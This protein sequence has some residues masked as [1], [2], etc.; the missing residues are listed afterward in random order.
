VVEEMTAALEAEVAA[1]SS[2]ATEQQQ[3][4][5]GAPLATSGLTALPLLQL[6]QGGEPGMSELRSALGEPL[7]QRVAGVVDHAATTGLLWGALQ[8]LLGPDLPS[9]SVSGMLRSLASAADR[10]QHAPPRAP[11]PW[12]AAVRDACALAADRFRQQATSAALSSAA[13]TDLCMSMRNFFKDIVGSSRYCRSNAL[14]L[15]PGIHALLDKGSGP[16]VAPPPE[17]WNLV[18]NVS[19]VSHAVR[20]ELREAGVV[21]LAVATLLKDP[22]QHDPAALLC[23]MTQTDSLHTFLKQAKPTWRWWAHS[24]ACTLAFTT[25]RRTAWQPA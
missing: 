17:L 11:Q 24:P 4:Q 6:L 7:L 21:Q 1:A 14:L 2:P 23:N 22:A 12:V 10:L 3:A 9:T 19:D 18:W 20:A 16:P 13:L 15:C 8:V 25:T 5:G